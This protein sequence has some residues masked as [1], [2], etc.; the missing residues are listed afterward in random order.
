MGVVWVLVKYVA[1]S[2]WCLLLIGPA[3]SRDRIGKAMSFGFVRLLIGREAMLV[4]SNAPIFPFGELVLYGILVAGRWLAWGLLLHIRWHTAPAG[5]AVSAGQP[6]P[7]QWRI[8]GV[9]VSCLADIP[10]LLTGSWVG[11]LWL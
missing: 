7:R 3:A 6:R 9:V 11:F 8:G 10:A 5:S 4:L 1:E 2:A